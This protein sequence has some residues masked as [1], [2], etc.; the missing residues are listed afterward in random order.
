MIKDKTRYRIIKENGK[1]LNARTDSPSWFT[2]E[3]AREIVNY[4][5]GQMIYEHDGVNLLWEVF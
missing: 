1:I 3:K 4:E 2:L 5:K